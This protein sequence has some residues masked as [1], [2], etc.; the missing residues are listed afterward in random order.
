LWMVFISFCAVLVTFF[1]T[2]F[3]ADGVL[4]AIEIFKSVLQ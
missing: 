3:N 4:R 2:I 1:I